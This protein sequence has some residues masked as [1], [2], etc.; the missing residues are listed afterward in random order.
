MDPK[1]NQSDPAE[2]VAPQRVDQ[3]ETTNQDYDYAT[4]ADKEPAIAQPDW[5]E[6]QPI[7]VYIVERPAIPQ[8][9]DWSSLRVAVGDQPVQL[10][11][12]RRNRTRTIVKNEGP[13]P[14]FVG[15]DMTINAMGFRLAANERE[16]FLHNDSIWARCD[17]GKTG[18][19][20]VLQEFT[21]EL[22]S[23]HV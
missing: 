14:V 1:H 17:A 2:Y 3:P 8:I 10:V 11:G 9:L 20:S 22:D 16:E 5:S 6:D 4:D 13:D 19:V 23:P 18:T 21:V 12:A 7:P 15:Q